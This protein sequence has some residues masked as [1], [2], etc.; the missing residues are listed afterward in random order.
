M[1]RSKATRRLCCEQREDASARCQ[2]A[3]IPDLPRPCLLWLEPQMASV[4][5]YRLLCKDCLFQLTVL[6]AIRVS[7]PFLTLSAAIR[8]I[9]HFQFWD[10]VRMTNTDGQMVVAVSEY[11]RPPCCARL[12]QLQGCNPGP[13]EKA[14]YT[15]LSCRCVARVM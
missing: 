10:H 5:I 11:V 8:R 1:R 9:L 15:C 13:R 14:I 2:A 4:N 6:T 12:R 3:S 7:P